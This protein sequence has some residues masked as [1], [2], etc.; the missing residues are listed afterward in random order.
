M[1]DQ[2]FVDIPMVLETPKGDQNEM[3]SVNLELLRKMAL[4]KTS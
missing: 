4:E 2:R 3:D 1:Q